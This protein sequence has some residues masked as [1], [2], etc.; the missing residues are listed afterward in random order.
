MSKNF[1]SILLSQDSIEQDYLSKK[2]KN[3]PFWVFNKNLNFSI[4]FQYRVSLEKQQFI[5]CYLITLSPHCI[6]SPK[7]DNEQPSEMRNKH[8]S[9]YFPVTKVLL[10]LGPIVTTGL[11][12]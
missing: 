7:D 11:K 2:I 12:Y 5:T 1:A 10:G 6:V 3:L 4:E 9:S 8:R